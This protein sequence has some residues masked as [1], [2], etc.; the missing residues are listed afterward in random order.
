VR[1]TTALARLFAYACTDVRRRYLTQLPV[2]FDETQLPQ[3]EGA[4]RTPGARSPA[5]RA[6]EREAEAGTAAISA[7]KKTPETSSRKRTAEA[8]ASSPAAARPRTD[9][10]DE[11]D[12]TVDAP[13]MQVQVQAGPAPAP[14]SSRL[15]PLLEQALRFWKAWY[16]S[17]QQ[18]Q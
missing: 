7:S 11:R 2:D 8:P 13:S 16:I 17:R 5:Q 14:G 9:A 12:L 15:R 10:T 3:R 18:H 1:M 4:P 6:K